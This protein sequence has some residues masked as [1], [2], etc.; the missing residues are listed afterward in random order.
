MPA[1]P[2]AVTSFKLKHLSPIAQSPDSVANEAVSTPRPSTHAPSVPSAAEPSRTQQSSRTP[3]LA[4]TSS[5]GGDYFSMRR[6]P[7]TSRSGSSQ[8]P[9]AEDDFSGW[10]G[11]GSAK[12]SSIHDTAPSTP[13]TPGGGLMGKL[14]SFGKASRKVA[15]ESDTPAVPVQAASEAQDDD[16]RISFFVPRDRWLYSSLCRQ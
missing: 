10:G 13:S 11:P 8:T 2:P 5:S 16:V 14:K 3:A 6:R 7:S 15:S 4:S 1:I 9:A 12:S